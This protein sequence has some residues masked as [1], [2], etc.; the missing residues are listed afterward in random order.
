MYSLY[1]NTVEVQWNICAQCGRHISSGGYANNVS[2]CIS[3]FL[4]TLLIASSSYE[5]YILTEL[6]DICI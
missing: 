1:V 5:A 4:V 6:S 3:V 2:V